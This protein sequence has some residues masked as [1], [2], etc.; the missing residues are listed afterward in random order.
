MDQSFKRF[1]AFRLDVLLILI[2]LVLEFILGM[3]T[4]LY[5][6]FPDSLVNGDA[7]QWSIAHSPI[8]MAHVLLGVLMMVLSILALGFSIAT[9]S[10]AAIS[11]SAVGLILMGIAFFSGAVF[12]SNIQQASYS[13][14]MSL[15]FIGATIVYVAAYYL[16][17]S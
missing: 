6:T 2:T 7:W 15:G 1:R 14:S 9:K 12:L 13:F 16:T 8:L 17:R 5:V 3:Y 11:T 10:S 4:A